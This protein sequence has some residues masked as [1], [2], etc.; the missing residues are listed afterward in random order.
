MYEY[1]RV[2]T[3]FLTMK[4][5]TLLAYAVADREGLEIEGSEG[6][7]SE[8]KFYLFLA[9]P[10]KQKKLRF[11]SATCSCMVELKKKEAETLSRIFSHTGI[12]RVFL[13]TISEA[14]MDGGG[15]RAAPRFVG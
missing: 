14:A 5:Y 1:L 3:V 7:G 15:V 10:K 6:E 13:F 12:F 8:R 2:R 9:L 11:R 4:R